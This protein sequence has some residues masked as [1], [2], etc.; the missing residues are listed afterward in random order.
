MSLTNDMVK[1]KEIADKIAAIKG[2]D[3]EAPS[4]ISEKTEGS[5]YETRTH[6]S[7]DVMT[8]LQ[9]YDFMTPVE[10]KAI[11]EDMWREMKKEDMYGFIR[12][13]MVAAAKNKPIK[14][15]QEMKQQIS[16]YIYEF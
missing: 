16:P 14:G 13:C 9:P 3:I 12:V 8:V 15:Q 5:Y 10:L 11:L 1:L 6:K 7:N 4:S 2:K